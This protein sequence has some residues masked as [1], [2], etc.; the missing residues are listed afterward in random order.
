METY[1]EEWYYKQK[2]IYVTRVK[3]IEREI[4]YYT[5]NQEE[6]DNS[7][8]KWSQTVLPPLFYIPTKLYSQLILII[9]SKNN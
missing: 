9:T 2:M 1:E 7:K 5:S 8:Q 6:M 4:K 3:T